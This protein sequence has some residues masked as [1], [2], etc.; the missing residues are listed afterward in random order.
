MSPP[1]GERQLIRVP[2]VWQGDASCILSR[3]KTE[4]EKA[5]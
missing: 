3:M 1:K 5:F 2:W 4:A